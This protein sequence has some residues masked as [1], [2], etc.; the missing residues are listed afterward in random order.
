MNSVR[1]PTAR[2]YRVNCT[3]P[4]SLRHSHT[5]P[6]HLSHEPYT[7]YRTRSVR[8]FE[9]PPSIGAATLRL[10][11]VPVLRTPPPSPTKTIFTAR[12][13][14]QYVPISTPCTFVGNSFKFHP[15]HKRAFCSETVIHNIHI[16][17]T[18]ICTYFIYYNTYK[19]E[20]C[21]IVEGCGYYTYTE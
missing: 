19:I 14:F 5:P 4:A 13:Y 21:T 1:R 9:F 20:F 6:Q 17:Y 2:T 12:V 3:L 18:Y 16:T 7:F 8:D 11:A 10:S 15:I